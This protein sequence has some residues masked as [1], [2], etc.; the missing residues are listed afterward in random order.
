[1]VPQVFQRPL[2]ILEYLN[3]AQRFF[4]LLINWFLQNT[5]RILYC[6]NRRPPVIVPPIILYKLP[7]CRNP[8]M[9]TVAPYITV[10]VV[11]SHE[12]FHPAAPN[13]SRE[14]MFFRSG[15]CLTFVKVR[16]FPSNIFN[17]ILQ[18]PIVLHVV[19]FSSRIVPYILYRCKIN[20]CSDTC[21]KSNQSQGINHWSV[22]LL[23]RLSAR[24]T[25]HL[26]Y[27][28]LAWPVCSFCCFCFSPIMLCSF[29]SLFYAY[30]L[31]T[32]VASITTVALIRRWGFRSWFLS[33]ISWAPSFLSNQRCILL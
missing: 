7:V 13:T 30:W 18:I 5:I 23:W 29:H 24:H 22:Y 2:L 1:M 16:T 32:E 15:T 19:L 12:N 28:I 14:I 33:S 21:D 3:E 11:P 10:I 27:A 4:E 17:L 6:I 8:L 25:I 9:A 31:L 20:S 26:S